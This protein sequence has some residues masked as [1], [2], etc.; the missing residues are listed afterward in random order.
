MTLN[1]WLR[2]RMISPVGSTSGPNSVS[3]TT[4]PSTATLAA[5]LT[6]CC[7]KKLPYF[8]G[9]LRISGKSTS[10]PWIWRRPVLVAGDHLRARVDAGR[11]VLDAGHAADGLGVLRRERARHALALA[12][13]ALREV[14]GV[15]VDHV[16]AG[17]LDLLFDRRLR[18]AAERDHR[19]D[20]ADADDHAE[21]GQHRCASCCG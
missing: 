1:G 18:A 17:R 19:D 14:A 11:H 2:M 21:H 3:A 10:A 4:V 6:S 20:R 15:D 9:Q 7:V 5:L 12:H 8:V 13:A 16:G